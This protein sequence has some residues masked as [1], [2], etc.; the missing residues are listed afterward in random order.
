MCGEQ[1]EVVENEKDGLR[2]LL[3]PNTKI[4]SVSVLKL[5]VYEALSY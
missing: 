5:L 1:V 2:Y 3:A 4:T